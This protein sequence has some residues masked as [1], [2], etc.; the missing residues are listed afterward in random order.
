MRYEYMDSHSQDERGP[1][2]ETIKLDNIAK[3]RSGRMKKDWE[4]S[5]IFQECSINILVTN[6]VQLNEF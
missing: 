2:I 1:D 6:S 4:Q 5:K 3:N